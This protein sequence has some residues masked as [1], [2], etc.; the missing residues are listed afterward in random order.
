MLISALPAIE[1]FKSL[2]GKKYE[3]S[4]VIVSGKS[5]SNVIDLLSLI[6][7]GHGG[8]EGYFVEWNGTWC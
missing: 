1:K 2:P 6:S 7:G 4:D 5:M 8:K 3:P